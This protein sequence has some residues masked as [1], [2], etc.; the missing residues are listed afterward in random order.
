MAGSP[1]SS[2]FVM[3]TTASY[4]PAPNDQGN[5]AVSFDSADYLAVWEGLRSSNRHGGI[6][7][8][9]ITLDGKV[10]DSAGIAV[11][12]ADFDHGYAALAF[13]GANFLVVW[14]DSRSSPGPGIY[15]ARVTPQ[16][17]LLDSA[18]IPLA[19]SSSPPTGPEIGFDGANFLVAWTTN[20]DD[21]YGT[22]VTPQGTMLDSAG[23]PIC[24]AGNCYYPPQLAFD[25]AN[26]LVVWREGFHIYAA[27][28]TPDGQVLDTAGIP[29]FK[30]TAEQA[31][32]GVAFDGT[33]Y[34]VTW[35]NEG[36][37]H[38]RINAARVTPVG[39][40]LDSDIVVSRATGLQSNPSVSF[41]GANFLVVW[42]D[43]RDTVQKTAEARVTPD[44][45]VLDSGIVLS[46]VQDGGMYPAVCTD[47]TTFIVLWQGDRGGT[48]GIYGTRLDSQ[49]VVL[50]SSG[51]SVSTAA[52]YQWQPAAAAAGSNFLTVW[53]DFRSDSGFDVVGARATSQGAVLD[54]EGIVISSAR[55]DQVR[56]EAGSNGSDYLV[57]WQDARSDSADVYAS[58]V[59]AQGV[60]LDSSG[61]PVC[62]S[63][64]GGR[65][66]P[67]IASDGTNYLVAWD[68]SRSAPDLS[69]DAMRVTAQGQLLDSTPIV[70]ALA[71]NDRHDPAI[72]FEGSYYLVVWSDHRTSSYNIYAARVTPDGEVYDPSGFRISNG[73]WDRVMPCVSAGIAADLVVWQDFR[74]GQDWHIYAA[75]IDHHGN[76]LDTGGIAVGTKTGS[77][78]EPAVSFDGVNWVVAWCDTT[79][80]SNY[81]LGGARISPQG[82]V[83]DTFLAVSGG[84][85]QC[86][87]ALAC[88]SDGHLL[89][90]YQGWTGTQ[91]GKVYNSER[92]WGEL[93]PLTGVA[94]QPAVPANRRWL[95]PSIVRG[96]LEIPRIAALGIE[97]RYALFDA[98]GRQRTTLFPGDNDVRRL[99]P[100]VYFLRL[101]TPGFEPTQKVV[102]AQ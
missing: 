93:G 58:R 88:A 17:R 10:L 26:Y 99:A 15:A 79:D 21:I 54:P 32:P 62:V 31:N 44:G 95:G 22:R 94:E 6:Y 81:R 39:V 83:I 80:R 63:S 97:A 11:S 101:Q 47:G 75:R 43:G 60:V 78:V 46:N 69:I 92:T 59:T 2:E 87:P 90:A 23:I 82:A 4:V 30:G 35:D 41:N 91:A 74:N 100:G 89:L 72:T 1:D 52:D 86:F 7:A 53:Q 66:D 9:R 64:Q 56:P 38:S 73:E 49:G 85:D 16:G 48:E 13:D 96:S 98:S 67:A 34:L 20:S 57:A 61:I 19:I 12:M 5:P 68:D 51:I 65:R 84:S 45:V 76:V 42:Q 24:T 3:D 77:Q 102:I 71:A 37:S 33:N 8:T 50:D 27:R 70:V 28:V 29:V 55:S 14:T 36:G 18:G 40:M 25:G